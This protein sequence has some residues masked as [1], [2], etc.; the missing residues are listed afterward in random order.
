ME[1]T[2]MVGLYRGGFALNDRLELSTAPTDRRRR[3]FDDDDDGNGDG[4]QNRL[5]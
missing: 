5:I 4:D 2:G 3:R 1:R